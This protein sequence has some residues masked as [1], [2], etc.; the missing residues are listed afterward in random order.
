MRVVHLPVYED[1]A[2]QRLLMDAQ[3]HLGIDAIAGGGGGNFFRTALIRWKADILHFHWIHPYLIRAG[4]VGTL[5]QSLRLVV[6]VGLLRLSGQRIVW[7]VHNLKN[8]DN[9]H[10][11]LERWFTKR[12]AAFTSALITH[13]RSACTDAATAFG[14]RSQDCMHVVPLGNYIGCYPNHIPRSDAR[15]RLGIPA[16][17]FVFLFLGR[18]QP[19]K[20]V[21]ELIRNFKSLQSG[22][23]LVIAGKPA[24][25]N[26]SELIRKE[27]GATTNVVFRP[28]FVPDDEIQVYLNACDFVVC[29]YRDVF[30]SSAVVLAMSFGRACVAPRIGSIGET[31][32]DQGAILY[33]PVVD[34][35]LRDA[36][37]LAQARSDEAA[38]MGAYNRHLAEQCGWDVAAA[39]TR[40]IYEDALRT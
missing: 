7:T 8:H 40:K 1:N 17:S 39:K 24:D 14:I 27:I 10:L 2:Y 37:R 28:G 16:E 23:R 3:R 18:I 33:N 19:Y 5:L 32:D 13:S 29:P 22:A 35:S 11:G 26:T 6:E 20:G 25:T 34:D 38:S 31:L 36:L 30:T 12:F 9:R 15:E 4:T 21:L